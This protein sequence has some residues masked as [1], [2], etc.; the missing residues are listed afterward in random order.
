MDGAPGFTSQLGGVRWTTSILID[1]FKS[2]FVHQ[3]RPKLTCR[4][5][6][7]SLNSTII[8][9]IKNGAGPNVDWNSRISSV[10]EREER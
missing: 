7:V 4:M 9:Q 8:A 3:F 6:E 10:I 2:N 1:L 5:S